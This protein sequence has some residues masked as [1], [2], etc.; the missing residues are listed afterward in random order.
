MKNYKLLC[1]VVGFFL[2]SC[3][4]INKYPEGTYRCSDFGYENEE[5]RY[6]FDGDMLY[7]PYEETTPIDGQ[8]LIVGKMKY[9]SKGI[10][11]VHLINDKGEETGS[12]G[13]VRFSDDYSFLTVSNEKA[14]EDLGKCVFESDSVALFPWITE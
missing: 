5:G 9:V 1:C 6:V 11:E 12:N 4:M 14:G 8:L 10:Y 7:F 13:Y 2:V 3:S